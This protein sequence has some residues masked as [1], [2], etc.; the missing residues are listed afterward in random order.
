M[1]PLNLGNPQEMGILEFAHTVNRLVGNRAGIVHKPLPVDDPK[2]RQPDIT[3][4]R[5]VLHWQPQ[6]PLEDGLQQTIAWF[7]Q[8]VQPS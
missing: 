8:R 5:Q 4:A 7:Q 1:L 6:V 2:V 3:L